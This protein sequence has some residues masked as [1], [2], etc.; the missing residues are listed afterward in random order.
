MVSTTV[1]KHFVIKSVKVVIILEIQPKSRQVGQETTT[2]AG[3]RLAVIC[4][5]TSIF[6]WFVLC[7][8]DVYHR[9][10]ICVLWNWFVFCEIDLCFGILICVLE[11]W[12]VFWSIDLCFGILIYVLE[13]WFV[14]WNIDL[15]FWK[16]IFVRHLLATVVNCSIIFYYSWVRSYFSISM[17]D[18]KYQSFK[19]TKYDSPL[20]NVIWTHK[21]SSDKKYDT[22][23][24]NPTWIHG[25]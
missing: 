7:E 9:I 13:Y 18:Q 19:K 15:C 5:A 6:F 2:M 17:F 21:T 20:Q 4:R 1:T 8:T 24:E 10:L 25:F 3:R 22:S 16:L 14:F 12:F 11:Y 23:F